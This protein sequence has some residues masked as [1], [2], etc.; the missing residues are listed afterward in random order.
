VET[1]NSIAQTEV[2]WDHATETQTS[3]ALELVPAPH[4]ITL[5][6]K[7]GD[8]RGSNKSNVYRRD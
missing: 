6:A 7:S 1:V 5:D 3:M 2:Q 8:S 4:T